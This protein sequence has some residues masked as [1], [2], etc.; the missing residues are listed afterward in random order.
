MTRIG[1]RLAAV[2]LALAMVITF[3]PVLGTHTAYADDLPEIQNASIGSDGILTWDAYPGAEKYWVSVDNGST[4][5]VEPCLN[6]A[7][8]VDNWIEA[9]AL[10]E[11]A[12]YEIKINASNSDGTYIAE[13]KTTYTYVPITIANVSISSEGVMTW[14]AWSG[15]VQYWV[16]VN[17]L[18]EPVSD[19]TYDLRSAVNHR[20]D[21]GLLEEL[22]EYNIVLIAEDSS[23]KGLAKWRGVYTHISTPITNAV[24]SSDGILTWDAFPGA[25]R[26]WVSVDRTGTQTEETRFDISMAVD[27]WI[28]AGG[29]LESADSYTVKIQAYNSE[30]RLL[31]V[32]KTTY[33]HTSRTIANAV[34]SSDGI[35]T[36]DAYPG[37]CK[38][39]VGVDGLATPEES[40]GIDLNRWINQLYLQGNIENIGSHAVRVEAYDS[41]DHKLAQWKTTYSYMVRFPMEDV[42][43]AGLTDGVQYSGS[44]NVQA[45]EVSY[46]GY[47]A[48]AGTDYSVSYTDSKGN[49]VDSIINAGT[50][51][52]V[53][54]GKGLYSGVKKVSIRIM[55]L[56]IHGGDANLTR[57]TYTY[58][59]KANKPTAVV[60]YGEVTLKEGIDYTITYKN[61]VKAGTAYAYINGKGNYSDS[62]EIGFIINK[63]VNPLK[64]GAKTASV[65]YSKLK[66]NNQTLAVTK[67]IKFTNTKKLKDKKTYTLVSAKKGSKSF[68]KYFKINKTTGKVTVKKGLKKGN[69]KVKVKVKA[70]G[71]ANY[72]ASKVKAVTFTVK[73]K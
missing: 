4:S 34:I 67:V 47:P 22:D 9:G 71:N 38:Y 29:G 3:I 45:P 1:K 30:D 13:W 6:L 61:N 11:K 28:E 40:N 48:V 18:A 44:A 23:G 55:P 25:V 66:N 58:S 50:Y 72:K 73:V 17:G 15:A 54:T 33:F 37:A 53:F 69:Y 68:K 32:W 7:M 46:L 51:Y 24:I 2:F 59:G 27:N 65:K 49:P 42:D 60:K 5:T 31:A 56:D 10:E 12:T 26:Y 36:W 70:A 21:S 41:K 8:T 14:D 16:S 20:I 63:A 52:A 39:W 57:T 19:T 43:V 62:W 35:L 64:I